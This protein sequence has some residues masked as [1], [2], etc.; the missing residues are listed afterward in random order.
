[1][2]QQPTNGQL[3]ADLVRQK[4][5]LSSPK[6]L[7]PVGIASTVGVAAITTNPLIPLVT[8]LSL[9]Y[10]GYRKLRTNGQTIEQSYADPR[11]L[12]DWLDKDHQQVCGQFAAL[13]PPNLTMGSTATKSQQKPNNQQKKNNSKEQ[14]N[15]QNQNK[16]EQSTKKQTEQMDLVGYL[17]SQIHLLVAATTGAGKTHFLRALSSTVSNR[18]DVLLIADPKGSQW[19]DL[20]PAVISTIEPRKYLRVFSK[21][22]DEFK[23]RQY[24]LCEGLDVGSHVWVIFDEWV[25]AKSRL[26][27]LA[28]PITKDEPP[29]VSLDE[30]E[31]LLLDVIVGGR[32]LNM[33]L[34]IITQSHQLQDLSLSKS[35]NTFSSGIRDNLCTVGLGCKTT[36]DADGKPMKGNAKCIDAMLSDRNLIAEKA[37]RDAAITKH[38]KIRGQKGANR[39]YC[40]YSSELYVG[41]TPNIKIQKLTKLQPLI[42]KSYG[43]NSSPQ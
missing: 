15:N 37:T 42:Q 14:G 28:T 32:E 23:K 29:E 25:L 11:V 10:Y 40:I 17:A 4:V 12:F 8:A 22:A 43:T 2:N 41:S 9:G 6:W 20:S 5:A 18:G 35:K 33:H 3:M 24:R 1:M 31:T 7:I 21:L 27:A 39:T 16:G 38:E 34:V 26:R 13:Y 30:L 19:G 36:Q